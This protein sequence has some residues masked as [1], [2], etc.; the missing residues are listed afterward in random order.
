MSHEWRE[1]GWE[2]GAEGMG[3]SGNGRW[4]YLFDKTLRISFLRNSILHFA[5]ANIAPTAFEYGPSNMKHAIYAVLHQHITCG[6]MNCMAEVKNG[7]NIKTY[8]PFLA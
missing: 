6:N 1:I 3:L 2:L 7:I 4:I 5:T 8:L